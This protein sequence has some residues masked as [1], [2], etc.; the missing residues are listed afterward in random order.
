MRWNTEQFCLLILLTAGMLYAAPDTKKQPMT[1]PAPWIVLRARAIPDKV[2][3]GAPLIVEIYGKG[4]PPYLFGGT[5]LFVYRKNAPWRFFE[6]STLKVQKHTK[7]ARYDSV[8]LGCWK[9]FKHAPEA[10]VIRQVDTSGWPPGEYIL[11][12]HVLFYPGPGPEHYRFS[13]TELKLEIT[14]SKETTEI[15]K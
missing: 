10:T 13:G 1:D 6:N 3:S 11:I 9:W 8:E 4:R 5:R 14:S 12:A 2:L 7:D 15:E